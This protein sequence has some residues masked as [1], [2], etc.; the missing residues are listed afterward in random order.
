MLPPETEMSAARKSVVGSVKL[1]LN[2]ATSPALSAVCRLEIDTA[3]LKV[4]IEIFGEAL[5]D[6]ILPA[7]SL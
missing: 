5:T 1:K 7:A 6:P 2:E 3:G 4:S